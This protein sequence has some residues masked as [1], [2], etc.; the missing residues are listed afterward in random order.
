MGPPRVDILIRGAHADLG[1]CRQTAGRVASGPIAGRP[2]TSGHGWP[3]PALPP[4]PW[5]SGRSSFATSSQPPASTHSRCHLQP[6]SSWRRRAEADED[7]SPAALR[8]GPGHGPPGRCRKGSWARCARPIDAAGSSARAGRGPEGHAG[9]LGPAHASSD[10]EQDDGGVAAAGE[11]ATLTGLQQ[12][13]QVLRP[14]T[15]I[16]CSGSC[17]DL[18]PSIGLT[19]RSP[20]ATA[21]LKKACRPGSG[22]AVAG[23]HRAN[24]SAMKAWTCSRWSWPTRSGVRLAVNGQQADVGVGL[25]GPGAL[26]LGLQSAA[27][28]PVQ[29]QQMTAWQLTV[30]ARRLCRRHRSPH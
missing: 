18:I 22:W 3:G 28:A 19:S 10:Q 30:G 16:G 23:F 9:A 8:P 4:W 13:R 1:A 25:D 7:V 6:A 12:P 20:S 14:T 5:C 27:E 11:V 24:W 17:G 29:D 15:S 26:V 2:G 21:H